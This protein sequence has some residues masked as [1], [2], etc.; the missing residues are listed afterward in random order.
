MS[1]HLVLQRHSG[2]ARRRVRGGVAGNG[3]VDRD[4]HRQAER[5][6]HLLH[7]VNHA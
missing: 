5:P 2:Q 3:A 4:E 6:A 7:D 1:E